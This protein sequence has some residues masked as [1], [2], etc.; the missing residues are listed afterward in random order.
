[1][2][3]EGALP[4]QT[5]LVDG[6]RIVAVG[7]TATTAVPAGARR[8]DGIG[9][10]LI[11][12]LI[13]MHVHFNDEHDALLFVA[14]GVTTVRN[15]WGN[16]KHLEWREKARANDPAWL[17]PAIYTAG[18]ILDGKPPV[19]PGSQVIET[20]EAAEA[21][22]AAEKKAGYDFVKVYDGLPLAA[23]DALVAAAK[24]ANLRVVGHIP[25]DAGLEHALASGQAT[26][27]HLTGYDVA[28]QSEKSRAA[29]LHGIERRIEIAANSDPGKIPDL[30][31][32][33]LRAGTANCPTLVVLARFAA[34][35]HPEVLAARPETRYVSPTLLASWDPKQDFRLKDAP[36]AMFAV[37]RS[38]LGFRDKLV[39][40]L[41]DA[42]A[43][44]F[45]GTDTPNPF[46]VPGFA[47]H[48]E[49]ALLVHAGLTPYQALR[50]ATAAPATWLGARDL[51]IV[52]PG[53]RA[54][55]VLLDADPLRDISAT[56]RRAGVMVRGRYF[57]NGELDAKLEQ[58]AASYHETKDRLA[59]V[60][61]PTIPG[62][63]IVFA[64]TYRTTYAGAEVGKER[65]AIGRMKDGHR[66]IVGQ[67]ANS[68]PE[69]ALV[70]TRTELDEHDQLIAFEVAAGDQRTTATRA[71][72]AIHIVAPHKTFDLPL[73]AEALFDANLVATMIPFADRARPGAKVAV[74]GR[75]LSAAGELGD[76]GYTFERTGTTLAFVTRGVF[77]AVSGTYVVDDQGFPVSLVAK[78]GPSE[79]A[80]R[81]E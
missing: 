45:A 31:A 58:L 64:A 48:E 74:P 76:V 3:M 72:N 11:P 34:L 81:R 5:V 20:A 51:G 19:W 57:T 49:L 60:D 14:N 66:V 15:M 21:E 7:P 41:V 23:Y 22:V 24:R 30:V 46:V 78:I 12:G 54:D 75:T 25:R 65:L 79:L 68:P 13:D 18:P 56:T 77:G 69:P 61:P 8:I 9:K 4:H 26:I 67:A 55:L 59:G 33:T 16:P 53:A 29:S 80:I 63:E 27:E 37:L 70:T 47:M 50:A 1:M 32:K 40:A 43:P 52:A 6:Q 39:K 62:A 35:D 36:P 73:P 71:G 42:G 10:F 38:G 17:G 28:A 44:V 2:T